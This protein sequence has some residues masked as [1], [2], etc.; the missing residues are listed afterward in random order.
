MDEL[1]E[2]RVGSALADVRRLAVPTAPRPW[3]PAFGAGEASRTDTAERA[4][5]LLADGFGRP[6]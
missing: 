3:P 4:E 6:A 1:P 2:D 5:E